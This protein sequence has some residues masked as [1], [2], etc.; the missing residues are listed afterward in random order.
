[1]S[2]LL[3]ALLSVLL[4]S[5][6]QFLLKIGVNRMG[7]VRYGGGEWAATVLKVAQQPA[8]IGGVVLFASSMMLWLG[9]LSRMDLSRAQ[10][11][12]ALSYAFVPVLSWAFLGETVGLARV[13]GIGLILVGVILAIR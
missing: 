12:I 3:T 5:V 2:A 6:G 1:M 8:I 10:P 7:G 9:V 4:G 11:M 13:A